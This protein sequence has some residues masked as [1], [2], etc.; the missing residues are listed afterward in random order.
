MSSKVFYIDTQIQQKIFHA[1]V[2]LKQ[3]QRMFYTCYEEYNMGE[4][5]RSICDRE[6]VEDAHSLFDCPTTLKL[7][8]VFFFRDIDRFKDIIHRDRLPMMDVLPINPFRDDCIQDIWDELD[9]HGR[10]KLTLYIQSLYIL[11]YNYYNPKEMGYYHNRQ[12]DR[13]GRK[14]YSI[15]KTVAAAGGAQNSF[16]N[17]LS[18]IIPPTVIGSDCII[19]ETVAQVMDDN[20]VS[21][22]Q[23]VPPS[24]RNP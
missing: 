2:M 12:R 19:S 11:I 16:C 5:F 13:R 10:E 14:K 4:E 6:G 1:H 17:I 15:N 21:T 9:V 3:I 18:T 24:L 20:Y 8:M 23:L 22:K 7:H